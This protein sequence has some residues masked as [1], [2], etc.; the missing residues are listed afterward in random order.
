MIIAVDG[1]AASGKGTLAKRL[2]ERLDLAY[3]DTGS[4]YRAVG[5]SLIRE[6]Y[7]ASDVTAEIAAAA[8]S[9]LNTALM[10]D[11][12]LRSAETG[13][14]ASV[15]AAYPAVRA[16]LL[17]HQ[18]QFATT[19]QAS[20]AGAILDGRDIGTV[21]LPEADAKFFVDAEMDIRARRRHQ[22]LM[23]EGSKLSLEDVK[24]QLEERD[25]RDKNRSHAPLIPAKDAIFVDT[26]EKNIE[27]MVAFAL[28]ALAG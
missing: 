5:L 12:A 3:L 9:D 26:S 2:A 16:H 21:V 27:E 1:T 13:Q 17:D 20:K 6:G 7:A 28:S 10:T 8:A 25:H 24:K 22:E 11:R 15:V 14:M 18:R 19:P 4:L 23:A